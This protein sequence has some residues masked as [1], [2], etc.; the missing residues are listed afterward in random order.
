MKTPSV[1]KQTL[2]VV[3]VASALAQFTQACWG[4]NRPLQMRDLIKDKPACQE[5]FAACTIAVLPVLI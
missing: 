3:A 4:K 1:A 2:E 5:H